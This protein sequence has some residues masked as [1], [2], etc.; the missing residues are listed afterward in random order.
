MI[1]QRKQN[2]YES[3]IN[4]IYTIRFLIQRTGINYTE[5]QIVKK[6]IARML[7]HF[8]QDLIRWDIRLS[9][10]QFQA[11]RIEQSLRA[12]NEEELT[13]ETICMFQPEK[14]N[15]SQSPNPEQSEIAE[16]TKTIKK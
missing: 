14:P 13:P 11:I 9:D 16:L 5:E 8:K 4:Y 15:I 6:I 12:I 10:L 2:P 7:P 1:K 3:A